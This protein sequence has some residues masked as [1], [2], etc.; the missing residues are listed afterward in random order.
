M[1]FFSRFAAKPKL[2]LEDVQLP[3]K[4]E[5][6]L[7]I[8]DFESSR[9]GFLKLDI[10]GES[11][12]QDVIKGIFEVTAD[13]KFPIFLV[14]E[15]GNQYDKNAIRVLV[16]TQMIGY[17]AKSQAKILAKVLMTKIE[18]EKL[19]VNGEASV[20]SRDGKVFG[21]FGSV[22]LGKSL[23]QDSEDVVAKESS[24]KEL[25]SAKTKLQKL[26]DSDSPES[27]AQ[28]KSMSRKVEPIAAQLLA[29]GLW[30]SENLGP[31]TSDEAA[32]ELVDEC[33]SVL[34]NIGEL[35]WATSNETVDEYEITS[36]IEVLIDALSK[37][38]G[39]PHSE[40]V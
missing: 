16:G 38:I 17:V 36:D 8:L 10:V 3:E 14:P 1:G 40:N 19:L 25:N 18:N 9:S 33:T 21:V 27:L 24:A 11:H 22:F 31:E 39:E 32:D 12:H 34:D 26:L 20:H 6:D 4:V 2:T 28:L 37:L 35:A 5:S 7:G 23:T 13:S 30:I 15:P 29:H